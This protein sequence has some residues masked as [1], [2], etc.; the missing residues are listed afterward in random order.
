MVQTR[1]VSVAQKVHPSFVLDAR[2][3]VSNEYNH[4]FLPQYLDETYLITV[5]G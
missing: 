3:S 1:G 5:F 4:I 2:A